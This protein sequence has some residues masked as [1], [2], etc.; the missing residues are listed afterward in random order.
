MPER[1]CPVWI[2]YLLASPVRKLFQ[3]PH[4]ILRPYIRK[5][6]KVMDIG[7]AMGFFSIPMSKIVGATG[8]VVCVD[9]QQKM[10]D[11]LEKK[12]RKAGISD[13]M[14]F[15]RCSPGS[16]EI[17]DI[18]EE[19]DFAL[20]FAVLHEVPDVSILFKEVY[21]AMKKKGIMLIAEPKGHVDEKQFQATINIA[22]E[23]GFILLCRP[24]VA[25]SL[26]ALIEKN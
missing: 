4:T 24:G 3:N 1:V 22:K 6:M 2:G 8:E 18:K 11:V 26:T 7:S 17:S 13:R 5:G 12:S 20:A 14:E 23:N 10:L 19:I 25:K 15:R 21:Q 9:L 16:L